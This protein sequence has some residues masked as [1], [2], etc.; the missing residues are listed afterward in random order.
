MAI[1]ILQERCYSSLT[2][3]EGGGGGNEG[4]FTKEMVEDGIS[5]DTL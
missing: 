5:D 1:A 4:D 3:G 2:Q